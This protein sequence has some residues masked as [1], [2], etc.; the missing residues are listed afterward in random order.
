M[1]YL[2]KWAVFAALPLMLVACKKEEGDT[3]DPPGLA[4]PSISDYSNLT[5]GNYWVYEMRE[6]DS[7]GAY[8]TDPPIYDSVYVYGDTIINGVTWTGL[9]STNS[10]GLPPQTWRRDSL[11]YMV[12]LYR[13]PVFMASANDGVVRHE[14]YPG[15]VA[16]DYS[17]FTSLQSISTPSGTHAAQEVK[18]MFTSL[19]FPVPPVYRLPRTYWTAGIGMVHSRVFYLFGGNGYEHTLVSYNV[20]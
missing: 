11:N 7:T 17:L 14:E 2:S 1:D 3:P 5:V 13:G 15:V 6:L 20:Q 12:D 4:T 19:G 9:R 16:V 8:T 18:G 10:G